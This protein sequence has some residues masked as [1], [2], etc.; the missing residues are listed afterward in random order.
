M[1][2]IN[3]GFL[4]GTGVFALL[5]SSSLPAWADDSTQ[6]AEIVVTAEKRSENLQ[7]VPISVDVVSGDTL[8]RANVSAFSDLAKFT[9]SMTMT[10]GDQPANSAIV[11]RG[12]GTF[13][14][15]VAAEPSVLVVIDDVAVGYQA[16]AFTDLVDIDRVEVLNGPQSTLFGKSASAGLV[17][18]TTKAPT[19]TFTYFGDVMVTNDDE[20]RATLSL[21]GPL[22]DTVAFRLSAAARYW[23]GNVHNAASGGKID[24]DRSGSVRG[25]IQWKPNDNLDAQFTLHYTEDRA[26]CCGVP[27]VRLDPG[28]HL[29]GV[30]ALTPAVAIA[31]VTPGPTTPPWPSTRYRR[32]TRRT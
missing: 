32:P 5:L 28:A 14:F 19:D 20:E 10:A 31:G 27:L 3:R 6:L 29:F 9:P 24:D 2:P 30:P 8:T 12:V 1:A 11:I 4:C 22:S 21:S 17:N 18:V 16:Q 25:K 26:D 7:K 15:S 13:A 23:G